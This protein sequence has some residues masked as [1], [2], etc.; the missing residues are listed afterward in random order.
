MSRIVLMA[1]YFAIVA[2]LCMIAASWRFYAFQSAPNWA[3]ICAIALLVFAAPFGALYAAG[4]I[5]R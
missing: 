5:G 1:L 2:P 4:R 3:A